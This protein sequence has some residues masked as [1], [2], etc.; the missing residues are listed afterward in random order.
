MRKLFRNFSLKGQLVIS[1][2][3]ICSII[4]VISFSII[5]ARISDVFQQ[6]NR[7]AT[8]KEFI[9]AESI[10]T[11]V[12]TN[13][14]KISKQIY[15]NSNVENYINEDNFDDY[16]T[17]S[18]KIEILKELEKIS[19]GNEIIEAI[20]IIKNTG[21]LVGLIKSNN[22][23]LSELP[24]KSPNFLFS[25]I[26]KD[27]LASG[28]NEQNLLWYENEER[29][30]IGIDIGPKQTPLIIGARGLKSLVGNYA[31]SLIIS[32]DEGAINE[33]YKHLKRF[34]NQDLYISDQQGR[35]ISGLDKQNIG[36]N[37]PLSLSQINQ[38]SD[39]FVQ[40]VNDQK[41]QFIYYK[42]KYSGWT[43]VNQI[44]VD[45]YMKDFYELTNTLLLIFLVA[46]V[47]LLLLSNFLANRITR[48]LKHL[49]KA[50]KEVQYGE[51]G[52]VIDE[53][54]DISELGK[55]VSRFNQMSI[56]VA[57]LMDKNR[58]E[59]AK[60]R[61]FEIEALRAQ[62]N[63]HFLFNTLNSVK[64]MA[65]TIQAKQIEETM[66]YLGRILQPLYKDTRSECS[67]GEEIDYVE[68]YIHIMNIR[69]GD[70]IRLG[71]QVDESFKQIS[72][73]RLILQPLVENSI[74]HGFEKSGYAGK[75]QIRL[76]SMH[77]LLMI[78]VE[79]DGS[80]IPDDQLR[81]LQLELNEERDLTSLSGGIGIANVNQRIKLH[82]GNLYGIH[83]QHREGGQGT[84]VICTLPYQ[85]PLTHEA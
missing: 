50:M 55:L 68:N 42:I 27:L 37:I 52:N 47:S 72:V 18:L 82:Y 35:I 60:K 39:S 85:K 23:A 21:D 58:E 80:G 26:Y 32:I 6:N 56:G 51:L 65:M 2:T 74:L 20:Y 64:W 31:A 3:F 13:I 16:E 25:N 22:F 84:R 29:T 83:I 4:L 57:E 46:I 79:D 40:R 62:I 53:E 15:F 36:R 43:L 44:P 24:S 11:N 34:E 77:D 66:M 59:E 8:V 49:V 70:Q 67:L 30:N 7:N 73:L 75:I 5:Y 9:Q 28:A 78:I 76:T 45:D 61:F 19:Q 17:V 69:Y 41:V 38:D 54:H 71:V 81:Q 10:I 63:P 1:F 48:P 14:D 33:V 12:K